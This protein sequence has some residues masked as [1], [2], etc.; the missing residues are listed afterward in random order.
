MPSELGSL[1]SNPNATSLESALKG[2]ASPASGPKQKSRFMNSSN[3]QLFCFSHRIPMVYAQRTMILLTIGLLIL[4]LQRIWTEP[5]VWVH[6]PNSGGYLAKKMF[7]MYAAGGGNFVLSMV[8]AKILKRSIVTPYNPKR[9]VAL[10][11]FNCAVMLT[12]MI[13]AFWVVR[14]SGSFTSSNR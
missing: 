4:L 14:K 6:L 1:P 11:I 3:N 10:N 5:Q 12:S 7:M 2:G 13:T 9:D 8:S